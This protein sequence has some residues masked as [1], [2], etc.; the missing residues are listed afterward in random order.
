[1]AE[2]ENK[3]SE[4]Y[5]K[6]MSDLLKMKLQCFVNSIIC[7]FKLKDYKSVMSIA[8]QTL[9]MEKSCVKAYFWKAKALTLMQE[10]D[11]AID[12]IRKAVKLEPANAE[13]LKE[14]ATIKELHNI[15]LKDQ[16]AKYSKLFK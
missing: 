15:F 10:Y 6:I 14:F 9:A 11:A 1:M 16:K 2:G 13:V 7:K 8:D 4:D 3:D 5:K 12:T